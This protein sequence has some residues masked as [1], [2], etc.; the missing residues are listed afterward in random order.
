MTKK[1]I[2]R[3][4]VYVPSELASRYEEMANNLGL[5]QNALMVMA[6][7]AYMDQQDTLNMTKQIPEWLSMAQE[8]QVKEDKKNG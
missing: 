2:V 3:K 6:L 5:T 8:I 4:G 1:K 7:H